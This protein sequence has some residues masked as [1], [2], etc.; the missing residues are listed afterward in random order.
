M[1]IRPVMQLSQADCAAACLA[2][3]SA[4]HGGAGALRYWRDALDC[5]RDGATAGHLVRTATARGLTARAYSVDGDLGAALRTAR[6][7]AILHVDGNHFLVVAGVRGGTA[8]VLDP[9]VGRRRLPL[10]EL[11]SR[12]SGPLIVCTATGPLG[13]DG[14]GMDRARLR[15]LVRRSVHGLRG[16]LALC[17]VL[18]AAATLAPALLIRLALGAALAPGPHA[19]PFALFGA[20]LLAVGAQF[21]GSLIQSALVLRLRNRFDVRLMGAFVAHLLGKDFA[22]LQGRASGD[23]LSRIAANAALQQSLTTLLLAVGLYLPLAALYTAALLIICW[24]LALVALAGAAVQAALTW[25]FGARIET[26]QRESLRADSELQVHSVDTVTNYAIVKAMR[27]ER[28]VA[29][30]WMSVFAE[31]AA[32]GLR[33]DSE[34]Q[35][36]QAA[37]RLVQSAVPLLVVLT[38]TVLYMRGAVGLGDVLAVITVVGVFLVSLGRLGSGVQNVFLLRAHLER[39]SDIVDDTRT[40]EEA[41]RVWS[42][43]AGGRAGVRLDAVTFRYARES[44]DILRD[45]SLAVAPGEMVGVGGPTGGG[46]STLVQ[47]VI[48]L[49]RP[50]RGRAEL[51]LPGADRPVRCAY[52]PQDPELFAGTIRDNVVAWRG[53]IGDAEVWRALDRAAMSADVA[54]MPLRLDTPIGGRGLH[55]SGGQRQRLAL[56]R[57]FAGD[58]DLLVADEPTSHLD[59]ATERHVLRTLRDLPYTRIVVAHTPRVLTACD[60]ALSVTDGRIAEITGTAGAAPATGPAVEEAAT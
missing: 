6:L 40:G 19:V 13:D 34:S 11:A 41:P 23:I 20:A 29:D 27:L 28:G 12:M 32:R 9:K 55:L 8:R 16:Q 36:L 18:V 17:V 2:M 39:L 47:L 31:A 49:Y 4:A 54:A 21:I 45:V 52:V 5:G 59:P 38:G 26:A 44:P 7:P 14:T 25:V 43:G 42:A 3:V 33:R 37:A 30:R 60:R 46:K 56:A 48:G 24:P 1:R 58:P 57:A 22:F 50:V 51:L 35:I 10:P 53:E 15:G